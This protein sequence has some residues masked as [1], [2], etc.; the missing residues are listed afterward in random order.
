M[1]LHRLRCEREASSV[2][3][4]NRKSSRPPALISFSTPRCACVPACLACVL[5]TETQCPPT[6][7]LG[8]GCPAALRSL[9]PGFLLSEQS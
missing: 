9:L 6:D 7:V 4:N 3:E 5:R 8:P 1:F 2:A